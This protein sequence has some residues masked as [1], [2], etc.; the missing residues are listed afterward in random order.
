MQPPMDDEQPIELVIKAQL[1]ASLA[2]ARSTHLNEKAV[3]R[4]EDVAALEQKVRRDIPWRA[5]ACPALHPTP[6]RRS[7]RHFCSP[8]RRDAPASLPASR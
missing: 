7:P 1:A 2:E 3:M 5:Y 8:T 6:R 4:V